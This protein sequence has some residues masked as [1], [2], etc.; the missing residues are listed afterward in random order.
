MVRDLVGSRLVQL[1]ACFAAPTF[2]CPVSMILHINPSSWW[3]RRTT[4]T[5][6]ETVVQTSRQWHLPPASVTLS[7]FWVQ[8]SAERCVWCAFHH[9]VNVKKNSIPRG[10]GY[11]QGWRYPILVDASTRWN[12]V[13]AHRTTAHHGTLCFDCD[14]HGETFFAFVSRCCLK[15]CFFLEQNVTALTLPQSMSHDG[16]FLLTVDR[17]EQ[18]ILNMFLLQQ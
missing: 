2:I 16:K 10:V 7:L 4:T 12:C 13:W 15:Y 9:G 5:V 14:M 8:E 3:S 11:W 6:T 1:F 17:D 18:V